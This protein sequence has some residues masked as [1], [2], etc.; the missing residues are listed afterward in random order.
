[1]EESLQDV[2]D[3]L[4]IV[5]EEQD[6]LFLLVVLGQMKELG[7]PEQ[8][9]DGRHS[10]KGYS[11]LESISRFPTLSILHKLITQLLLLSGAHDDINREELRNGELTNL[12]LD[13]ESSGRS[14]GVTSARDAQFLLSVD[15]NDAANWI[16]ENLPLPPNPE[17]LTGDGPLP[18]PPAPA[19]QSLDINSLSPHHRLEDPVATTHSDSSLPLNARKSTDSTFTSEKT[20]SPLLLHPSTESISQRS[21]E[22]TTSGHSSLVSNQSPIFESVPNFLSPNP[23]RIPLPKELNTDRYVSLHVANLPKDFTTTKLAALFAGINVRAENCRIRRGH[24]TPRHIG[25]ADVDTNVPGNRLFPA[26]L[27][28]LSKLDPLIP[29]G[30]EKE[31]RFNLG[32]LCLRLRIS[33]NDGVP[34]L[35]D[36]ARLHCPV[37]TPTPILEIILSLTTLL[38]PLAHGINPDI[39]HILVALL[40]HDQTIVAILPSQSLLDLV[41]G[42]VRSPL[43]YHDDI[44]RPLHRDEDV[45]LALALDRRR[46]LSLPSITTSLLQ[47]LF[48]SSTSFVSSI[49]RAYRFQLNPFT[50]NSTGNGWWMRREGIAEDD[51]GGRRGILN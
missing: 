34:F 28:R 3:R 5:A 11:A 31:D 17:R 35:R 50:A 46:S 18:L 44:A 15:I 14:E 45:D 25:F 16:D 12:L 20:S 22:S 36:H 23:E 32:R 40:R 10:W 43:L 6:V 30:D 26:I 4:V 7:Y 21:R 42:N 39:L 33:T 8:A 19:S 37:R 29:I 48:F 27:L 1:M 38:V 51:K 49:F 2:I 9:R 24:L 41:R 47:L 13:W